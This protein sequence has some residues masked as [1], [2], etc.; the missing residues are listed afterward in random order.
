MSKDS[1][2]ILLGVFFVIFVSFLIFLPSF[3]LALFGDDWLAFWRYLTHLGPTPREHWTHISY[4]LTPYGPQ[5]ITMGLLRK[6]FGFQG[7]Y[8][9]F[10]SYVL[11]LLAAFSFYPIVF[12]LTKNKLATFFAML[13]FS[14]TTTGIE[15]TNWVFNMPTYVTIALF[16]LFLYFFIRAREREKYVFLFISLLLYYFAYIITPIRMHGS[17]PL[18]FL[19]E[20]FWV[21]QKKDQQAAKL[22]C[23]RFIL[24]LLVFLIIKLSGQSLGPSNEPIE[25]FNMGIKTS[26]DTHG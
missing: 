10:I 9:H 22:A 15:A 23:I 1:S 7:S 18:I 5:D 2:K 24:I 6:I 20:V 25:R 12:Y 26:V 16:N 17:V 8:Y 21:L 19:L 13:F 4:F 14:V 11:R 3:N